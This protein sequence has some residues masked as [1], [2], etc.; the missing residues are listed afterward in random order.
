M[1]HMRTAWIRVLSSLFG[2]A[3]VA[4]AA[5][6][7]YAAPS[8]VGPTADTR[9][10]VAE[11][12]R[13]PGVMA[14]IGAG[15]ER[16]ILPWDQIQPDTAGDF[17]HLGQSLTK[18]QIQ[19]ELNRGTK[20]A[21]LFQ[22]TPGWAASNPDDGKRAVPKN[23]NLAFDDPNNYFGQYVF[24]TA[25]FYAAQIDQ[26][27]IWN[28]PEFK[29]G[30]PGAGGSY[31][32]LGSDAEFAQLMKVGYL[33]VKQ[34]SPNAVVSFP[35]TSY[36]VDINSNRPLFYD[37]VLSILAQDPSAAAN[38]YYHDVVSLN[39]Y[40]AP[41]D[42]YRV[43]GVFKGIQSKYGIDKPVW[44]TETNAMP[45][46][47]SSVPCAD[48]HAN[49]AIKTTMDQQAAYAIQTEALAAAAGYGKIEFY[50]MVDS[51]TCSE[52]AVWGVTRDDGS[53][54]PVTAALKVADNNFGGYTSAKFVPLTRE[55]AGWSAWPDDPNSL[56]PNWQVYQVALDK[57]G[58]QRVTALW[59]GDGSSLRVRIPKNG[60]SAQVV[61]RTGNTLALQD[62][63]GWWVVDLPA[64]TA[65]FKISE[66][67]KDPEGYHFI[68]GD[69]L[70]IVEN[71]VAPGAP[72]VT[73][74]LGDPGSVARE[75]KVFVTPDGG[76]TVHRGEPADFFAETRSYEG[77]S[78][79]INFSIVQWSTQ[80]F[81]DPK[82]GSTLPL[83]ASVPS[84]VKPGDSAR[85]HF[86]TVGADPGIYFIKVQ[87]DAGGITRAFD[88]AL[89]LN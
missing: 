25:K 79:A 41:D 10:G 66:D 9:F 69:P 76:Q 46:D 80:R 48:K 22:F 29:P 47:D 50:Q 5:L 45:S 65:Y 81:P 32:W 3:V 74:R 7:T 59:N 19:N 68:G 15:W 82:D 2:L 63:Q 1:E 11:G 14:D 38:N 20:I 26:W 70:L 56:V 84:G 61:D 24:R 40:R 34:A 52:P 6:P 67:I 49:E 71:G 43:H 12:F 53:R 27:I 73:P 8:A 88:L 62:N 44:L 35:G 18:N 17:S 36:W 51:N 85:L 60:S 31:T 30:D 75:Y 54:R 83:A 78:D 39:L 77:F 33:A 57:P 86:E 16:L 13:N 55:T 89:V 64:A 58:N 42:V 72:V 23:L 4:T 87:A 28:E 37:R 21:G